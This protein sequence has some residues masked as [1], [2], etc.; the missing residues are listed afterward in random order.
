[1]QRLEW[2]TKETANN[3]IWA[4]TTPQTVL[5]PMPMFFAPSSSRTDVRPYNRTTE[6]FPDT[7]AGERPRLPNSLFKNPWADGYDVESGDVARELR[8]A[9]R[10]ERGGPDVFHRLAGRTFEH[11]WIPTEATNAIAAQKIEASLLLRPAQDDF[12]KE[13]R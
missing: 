12:R 1:M 4:L 2:D 3:R 10:E 13:M 5:G 11:Q 8:G 9:V 7:K 6:Y